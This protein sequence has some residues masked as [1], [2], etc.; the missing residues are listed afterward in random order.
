MLDSECPTVKYTICNIHNT[1]SYIIQGS[2]RSGIWSGSVGELQLQVSRDFP[3]TIEIKSTSVF[4][5]FV[6]GE[7]P[8]SSLSPVNVHQRSH[9]PVHLTDRLVIFLFYFFPIYFYLRFS[10]AVVVID[11]AS[12][13]KQR[14]FLLLKQSVAF[15]SV[16][17]KCSIFFFLVVI[18]V[19]LQS[20]ETTKIYL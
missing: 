7:N 16:S 13:A 11:V 18:N 2:S 10:P 19:I 12:P 3:Q 8:I 1:L 20:H 14:R 4:Y 15:F 6:S 9:T 5:L 17:S